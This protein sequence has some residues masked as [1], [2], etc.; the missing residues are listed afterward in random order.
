MNFA[1]SNFPKTH[2]ELMILEAEVVDA[3]LFLSEEEKWSW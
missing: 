2:K 3:R 1:R